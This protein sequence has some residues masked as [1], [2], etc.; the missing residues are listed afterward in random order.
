MLASAREIRYGA[1]MGRDTVRFSCHH[2]NHCCTEVVCLPTP[3]DVRRIVKWTDADPYEFLEF[4]TP[5][6]I[7]EVAKND[8]TWLE[9]DGERHIMALRR[10]EKKGCFFLDSKTKLCSIYDGRPILCRLYPFKLQET[11]DGKFRGFGLH[12]DVGCPRHQDGEVPTKPLYDLYIQDELNQEDYH[13]LVEMFNA[14]EYENKEPGDFIALF[15][16]GFASF[17]PEEL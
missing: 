3:W 17:D 13:E 2:C 9:C 12:S 1:R 5:D 8:P 4:L 6:E 14:E 11:R 15:L 10:E 7:T 16:D